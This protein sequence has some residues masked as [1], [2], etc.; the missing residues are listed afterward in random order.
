MQEQ[1]DTALSE[2]ERH[3]KA[4]AE[5]TIERGLQSFV[6]VGEALAKVRDLRLYRDEYGTFEE[7]AEKK[8]SLTDRR[9]RQIIDASKV[10]RSLPTGTIV[11]ASEGQA[12]EL[13]GLAPDRAADV[14]RKAH[15]DTG[16]KVT[17]KAIKEARAMADLADGLPASG[18]PKAKP[19]PD[20]DPKPA[21]KADGRRQGKFGPRKKHL[22]V[23]D[24]LT[25]SLDGL[26]VA[27][28]EI[29]ALDQSVTAEEA[30]RLTSDLSRQIK[31]LHDLNNLLKERTK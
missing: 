10:T 15:D 26:S 2:I 21:P 3:A 23:L 29:T 27:A 13:S 28:K 20:A 22:F 6:E 12:R 8:W 14:M 16:G 9:L 18:A 31:A 19:S 25:T 7:Y 5:Q 11:P 4:K 1:I 24:N 17:A 30:A